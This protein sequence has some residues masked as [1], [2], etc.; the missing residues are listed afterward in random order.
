MFPC[1]FAVFSCRLGGTTSASSPTK[2][3]T[4]HGLDDQSRQGVHHCLVD[5]LVLV[6][7]GTAWDWGA[8]ADQ[9]GM[10]RQLSLHL[11]LCL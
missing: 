4:Q 8:M 6:S 10:V 7:G 9:L 11:S 2:H 3:H 1:L 5:R